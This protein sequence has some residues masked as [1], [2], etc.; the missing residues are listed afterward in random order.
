[1][2]NVGTTAERVVCISAI[3]RER[4]RMVALLRSR[5]FDAE[6]AR[7]APAAVAL[8]RVAPADALLIDAATF[9]YD[10]ARVCEEWRRLLEGDA[11]PM[12][13]VVRAGDVEATTAAL[14]MGAA[15]VVALPEDVAVLAH[16]LSRAIEAARAGRIAASSGLHLAWARR[17][18]GLA[19]WEHEPV[20]GMFVWSPEVS[21]VLGSE[22]EEQSTLAEFVAHVHADDR[23]RVTEALVTLEAH[24]IEYRAIGTSG[25]ERV[26]RH[27]AHVVDAHT[28]RAR[29][30]G[31]ALD[32]TSLRRVE[33][34]LAQ[35]THFDALTGLS[36]R[37][38]LH[39]GLARALGEADGDA[40][41]LCV[42]VLCIDLDDFK[43]VNDM[44]G[45][46][47]GDSLLREVA[48]RIA[49]CASTS[50]AG[51]RTATYGR[52]RPPSPGSNDP[53][54]A[55]LGG[56]DFI[57]V[58]PRADRDEAAV[59]ARKVADCLGAGFRFADTEVF[60]TSSIGMACSPEDGASSHELLER[61]EAAM[62]AAK[63]VGRDN[64]QFFTPELHVKARRRLD[65]DNGLRAAIARACGDEPTEPGAPTIEFHLEYQPKVAL[66]T[67][68]AVGVEALLR[69][70]SPT[71]GSVSPA[72]FIPVAEES[73]LIVKLG[74]WVLG[75]ACHQAKAWADAG[76]PLRV[77]VNVSARQFREVDFPTTV[78][79]VLCEVG[80]D[81]E[82]LELEITE[83]VIMEDT[84]ACC[85]IVLELKQ[86]G[87][88]IALDDF[89]TGHSSLSYLARLPIDSL[90][91]D[92]S[93]IRTIGESRS[94]ETI[95]AAI[96][97]LSR[98]LGLTVVAEGVE[99][100]AQLAFVRAHGDAEIQGFLFARPMRPAALEAWVR[101]REA[102]LA[103]GPGRRAA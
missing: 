59:F 84:L 36:N 14:D 35:R 97:A 83:G 25:D 32:V 95:T 33:R 56:D 2:V 87:I 6:E 96:I 37:T 62:Y 5:G 48:V 75:T 24:S 58:L 85:Q 93:F 31:T 65:I 13:M 44:I 55:R 60:V 91:I 64:F 27:D 53:I 18:A 39:E 78:A 22:I 71:L 42:A 54:V 89:G 38:G 49:A 98:G 30:A 94:G 26:I 7:D 23:A 61:A 76:Q 90:K 8:A 80:V 70:T 50:A 57:V 73:G 46:E 77:A 69:W 20:T 10:A 102:T 88:R 86:L 82:L 21:D 11:T 72:E 51:R 15:E 74:E 100:E 68:R 101:D 103:S 66:S 81:P 34:E 43:R 45:H 52:S 79:T 19:L 12:V 29:L 40:L 9:G 63:A 67:G 3:P 16:R 92:R 1:M 99:T 41:A 28:V 17:V 4:A 47:S